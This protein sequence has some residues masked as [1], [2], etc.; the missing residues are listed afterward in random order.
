MSQPLRARRC[1]VG[2]FVL[3]A[4]PVEDE[5]IQRGLDRGHGRG[6]SLQIDGPASVPGLFSEPS[7]FAA[8]RL[9]SGSGRCGGIAKGAAGSGWAALGNCEAAEQCYVEEGKS[10]S[11]GEPS[12][13]EVTLGPSSTVLRCWAAPLRQSS[14]QGRCTIRPI[15]YAAAFPENASVV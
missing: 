3:A 7:G 14:D 15:P 10:R 4:A 9:P 8:P 12:Q 13:E 6:Q 5:L 11:Y 1:A 2:E